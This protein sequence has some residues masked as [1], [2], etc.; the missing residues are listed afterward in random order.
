VVGNSLLPHL[1][2]TDGF[3]QAAHIDQQSAAATT[4]AGACGG[5]PGL[6]EAQ[7]EALA[8]SSGDEPGARIDRQYGIVDHD[9][10]AVQDDLKRLSG[11]TAGMEEVF[12]RYGVFRLKQIAA[13][14]PAN[15]VEFARVLGWLRISS[16]GPV[17]WASP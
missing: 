4:R 7:F 13:W 10:P 11:V 15:E 2:A 12:H 8:R 6:A 1:P 17:A 14:T 16:G 5:L 9:P 3:A